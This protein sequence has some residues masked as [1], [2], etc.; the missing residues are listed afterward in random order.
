[1][2]LVFA[3]NADLT[4]SGEPQEITDRILTTESIRLSDPKRFASEI[5][6]LETK[7]TEMSSYQKCHL[8][9][10]KHYQTAFEGNNTTALEGLQSMLQRCDDLRVRIRVNALIANLSVMSGDFEQTALN[11]DLVIQNAEQTP[12][13]QSRIMAYSVASIVYDMLGQSELSK[14]YSELLYNREPNAENL[15]KAT[16]FSLLAAIE[17]HPL[18]DLNENFQ[19]AQQNCELSENHIVS[20]FSTVKFTENQVKHFADQVPIM[21]TSLARL[22]QIEDKVEAQGYKNLKALFYGVKSKVLLQLKE[23]DLAKDTAE[24]SLSQNEGLGN[25]EQYLFALEVLEKIALNDKNYQLSYEYLAKRNRAENAN[26]GFEQAKQLAF[27]SVQHANLAK[28]F[29]IEQLNQQ[30]EVLALE[31]KLAQQKA[32]NQRLLILLILTIM[33]FLVFWS[34]RIKKRHDYF[35]DVSEIDHL[36]KVLTRKAFEE[37][38]K[39]LLEI[40][41][42][43]SQQV[44]LAI[45]DLDLFKHVNDNHGH[46]IGDWVL[47]NVIYAVKEQVTENML[48]ARLGGEEFC[49]VMS[50]TDSITMDAKL[51]KMRTAIEHLD[52]SDSGANLSVTA[53][54]GVTSSQVSG[55]SLPLL[56]THADVA[57]FEAKKKGRNKVLRFIPV[58][59]KH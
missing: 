1:L 52:C 23:Y 29:E 37:Q 27:M 21:E 14:K 8:E 56:L 6:L 22:T 17:K 32:N 2:I 20:A 44:Q 49:L 58:N 12:D 41:T 59:G 9:Y 34:V 16:Y 25:T 55:Y 40:A 24:I 43:K 35:K 45:M 5:N 57:L 26:I 50:N 42:E 11:I 36:T 15:C 30:N 7:T 4:V 54:F 13:K 38:V 3:A 46:L 48:I 28:V 18:S 39:K 47:K 10:L 51:E 33:A 31:S 53:S 19:K